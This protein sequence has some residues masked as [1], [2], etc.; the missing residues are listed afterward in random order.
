VKTEQPRLKTEDWRRLACKEWKA[1]RKLRTRHDAR[2]SQG[3]KWKIMEI[4]QHT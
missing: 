1:T 2:Q 4:A 3:N